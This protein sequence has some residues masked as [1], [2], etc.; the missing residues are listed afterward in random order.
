MNIHGVKMTLN[1]L[2][3]RTCTCIWIRVFVELFYSKW[4]RRGDVW[5][6][7]S[8]F[9]PARSGARQRTE[10]N[11]A[12]P[13]HPFF[14]P[15]FLTAFQTSPP[16]CLFSVRSPWNIHVSVIT[17]DGYNYY[18]TRMAAAA[19]FFSSSKKDRRRAGPGNDNNNCSDRP[20]PGSQTHALT[21]YR[22][23]NITRTRRL[24]ITTSRI[25]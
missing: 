2:C 12:S 7:K 22:F 5:I 15:H 16:E 17:R 9:G 24:Y 20:G 21:C 8:V 23:G 19:N 4:H 6:H 25:R 3:Q 1:I 18:Y 14:G 11:I 10:I 13:R